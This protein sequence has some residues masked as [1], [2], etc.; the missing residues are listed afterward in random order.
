[1]ETKQISIYDFDELGEN[2]KQK[3]LNRFREGNNYYFLKDDLTEQL[4][5]TLKEK[6]IKILKDF[7]LR[8]SLGYSQGD[9]FSFVGDFEYKGVEF[10]ITPNSWGN[11]Y[12]HKN[13]VDIYRM[14]EDENFE[15]SDGD[16][17]EEI[18]VLKERKAEEIYK[19]FQQ[20]FYNICDKLEKQGYSIIEYEDSDENIKENIKANEYKFRE[21]GDIEQ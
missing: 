9:G 12:Q 8:Y 21:N 11:H 17:T 10:R 7:S 5:E 19:E 16:I 1:M 13:S 14:D 4:H 3:V 15:D 2:A 6:G 18:K 20:V